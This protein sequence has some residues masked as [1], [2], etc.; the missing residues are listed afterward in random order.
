M[1]AFFINND[2]KKG[3]YLSSEQIDLLSIVRC[4][5]PE[6]L[7]D[8]IIKCE[9]LTGEIKEE[10]DYTNLEEAKRKVF[11]AFQD[12]MVSHGG[13]SKTNAFRHFGITDNIVNEYKNIRENNRALM[14]RSSHFKSE[15]RDQNKAPY[16]Y[17]EMVILNEQ[18][19]NFDVF[20]LGSGR[21]FDTIVKRVKNDD[22]TYI[23]DPYFIN[24]DLKFAS[25]LNKQVRY[26]SLFVKQDGGLFEGKSKEEILSLIKEYIN[27][28]IKY[29]NDKNN[30]YSY[31]D[32]PFI[33]CIDM[34]NELVSFDLK[35]GEYYNIWKDKYDISIDEITNCFNDSLEGINN[36][37][38]KGIS[39]VYNEPFL[40]DDQRRKMVIDTFKKLKDK[41]L[42][43]TLGSQMHI[44]IPLGNTPEEMV[45]NGIKSIESIK[46]AF[47]D[48]KK[49]QD[50]GYKI[51]ITEF[52]ISLSRKDIE[53]VFVN[54]KYSIEDIYIIKEYMMQAISNVIK[55]SNVKLEG[56]SYWSLTDGIDCNTERLLEE[57]KKGKVEG[58]DK[59]NIPEFSALGGLFP[60]YDKILQRK[61]EISDM[62][63]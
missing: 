46:R 62:S 32:K 60:T 53:K 24:R 28:S 45:N 49:L 48:F 7:K 57:A 22:G 14:V 19:S 56:I 13:D 59:D 3:G 55:E 9:Q 29:I 37:K 34:F 43:D 18:L 10:I 6:E 61:K 25:S 12:S 16:M 35:D 40:E 2:V 17:E 27:N 44:T 58:I 4:N 5:T 50:E 39:L 26:H 36:L 1:N 20:N 52:D 51:E 54:N 41:G 23:Y 38:Q 33:K 11:K 42:V 31:A 47:N 63:L 30:E 15:E 21:I 8:F